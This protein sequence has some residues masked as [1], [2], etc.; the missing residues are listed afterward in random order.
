MFFPF[1]GSSLVFHFSLCC[2]WF[3]KLLCRVVL[4]EVLQ[5]TLLREHHFANCGI[6]F[7]SSFPAVILYVAGAHL[8][9]LF[10]LLTSA[11][12]LMRLLCFFFSHF[13]GWT[14]NLLFGFYPQKS[15]GTWL[16]AF[17]R[18]WPLTCTAPSSMVR[19]SFA[20]WRINKGILQKFVREKEAERNM[21]LRV[22]VPPEKG[23]NRLTPRKPS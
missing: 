21:L 2:C 5:A 3:S 8:V 7:L 13:L 14:Q 18:W 17:E 23:F 16:L 15:K 10:V 1:V 9:D 4:R 22:Q 12:S 6:H 19:K 11:S 20:S